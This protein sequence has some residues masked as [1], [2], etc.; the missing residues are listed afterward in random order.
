MTPTPEQQAITSAVASGNNCMVNA[1]AGC[2]KTTSIV[3]SVRL[4]VSTLCLA[5]NV[6]IKEEL[7][8]RIPSAKVMTLN[9]LGH[10]AISSALRKRPEVDNGKLYKLAKDKGLGKEDTQ[11]VIS[12]VRKARQAGI[13]PSGQPGHGLTPDED[14][15]WE[16]FAQDELCNPL[17][18]VPARQV[19]RE[20]Y[21][22]AATGK[23]IDFDDQIYISA[24]VLG[25]FPRFDCVFVDEAQD[26]SS[27]NHAQLRKLSG[28][29]QLVAVG[30]PRQAIYAFRGADHHSMTHLRE[31]RPSWQDLSLTLT[32]RCPKAVVSRLSSHAVGFQAASTNLPGEV[33]ALTSWSPLGGGSAAVICRNNKPL[34]KLAFRLLRARVPFVLNGRDMGR[35]MRR[36]YTSLPT[37]AKASIPLAI[38]NCLERM[39]SDPK[40]RDQWEALAA[41]LED[42]PPDRI[43]P[44]LEAMARPKEGALTLTTGHKAKGLE[45]E[46]VYHL[47]PDLI[48]SIFATTEDELVQ[49]EN[50]RYVIESRTR[51]KLYL[52]NLE[53]VQL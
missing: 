24:L 27:L 46:I 2:A 42:C 7:A 13:I 30:D 38:G 23:L 25:A 4:G 32:F 52:V 8:L 19:H 43:E 40:R 44:T 48:P 35:T 3:Q 29:P 34:V 39:E 9:G 37:K 18:L 16:S 5:F 33:A 17:L 15:V 31:L 53:G 51:N 21:R 47:N 28:S 41:V 49:E 22:L 50:L 6:R 26:L 45:W 12:I 36:L 11:D 10:Q 1:L 14:H 20:S